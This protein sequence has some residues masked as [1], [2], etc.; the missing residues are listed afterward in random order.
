MAQTAIEAAEGGDYS[1][2]EL[3]LKILN[4]PFVANPEAEKYGGLPPDWASSISVSC[5]S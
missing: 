4:N 5:S 1:E 2:V 3:L